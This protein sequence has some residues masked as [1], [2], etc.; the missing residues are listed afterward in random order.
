MKFVCFHVNVFTLLE[1]V[2]LDNYII[3]TLLMFF[4]L[5]YLYVTDWTLKYI[6]HMSWNKDPGSFSKQ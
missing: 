1:L 4:S 3:P 5:I 2:L 6:D